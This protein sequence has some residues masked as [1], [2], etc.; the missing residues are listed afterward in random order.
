MQGAE[1]RHLHQFALIPVH[2]SGIISYGR[3]MAVRPTG[4]KK[5][6][7]HKVRCE[8][9][10]S[11]AGT[12]SLRTGAVRTLMNVNNCYRIKFALNKFGQNKSGANKCSSNYFIPNKFTVNK[13]LLNLF[14]ANQFS[15]NKFCLNKFPLNKLAAC[16]PDDLP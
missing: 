11:S 12:F 3:E 10:H 14:G 5:F 4:I 9:V 13:F 6:N 7:D 15:A 1:V 8:Q 2:L 16:H